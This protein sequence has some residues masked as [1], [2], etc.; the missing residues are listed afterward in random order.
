GGLFNN[1]PLR[2][3]KLI[4][5]T[6]AE[7]GIRV[8]L[9]IHYPGLTDGGA[10]CQTPVSAI[11]F[12]PTFV[13][14]A[15]GKKC[16]DE[17]IQGVSILPLL[18]GKTIKDRNIYMWR[19]YHDQYAALIC[20]DWKIIK[21]FTGKYQM[22]NLRSDIGETTD[23]QNVETKR[24]EK[25]KKELWAWEQEAIPAYEDDYRDRIKK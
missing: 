18:K 23:L 4:D 3:C 16:K 10:T 15:T 19:S 6:L 8:P 12:Y 24:F 1:Y 21:W 5:D 9:L 20:G 22:Y 2:G 17:Q 13:E 14:I 25:M 7:G 11:D